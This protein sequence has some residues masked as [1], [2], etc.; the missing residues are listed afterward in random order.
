M[1]NNRLSEIAPY[2]AEVGLVHLDL[3]DIRGVVGR[4]DLV[5]LLVV[6]LPIQTL[7]GRKDGDM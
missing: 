1:N 6:I 3:F 2:I 7:W 5:L 4:V